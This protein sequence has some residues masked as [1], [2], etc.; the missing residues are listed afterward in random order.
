MTRLLRLFSAAGLAAA[1]LAAA[2]APAV[3]GPVCQGPAVPLPPVCGADFKGPRISCFL[4]ADVEG[5]LEQ[6]ALYLR[7]RASDLFS[8]QVL[9]ALDWPALPGRRGEP[10]PAKPI[11]APGPRVW[12]TWKETTEVFREKDGK[13]L[14][15]EPWNA[16]E[17]LPSAC[18]GAEKLLVRDEKVDDLLDSMVQPTYADGTLPGTLTDQAGRRV[19]Y[20][21]RLNRT[22]FDDIVRKGCGTA[23]S[24][25]R[26]RTS[27][28]PPARRS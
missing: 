21:I 20:E 3:S 27:A 19:R 10:D 2:Q 12:E 9:I 22:A 1:A 16:P 11:T 26:R 28:S 5:G 18:R 13:P 23:P 14:P 17:V 25:P 7:Q 6:P 15:P 8:W 24:R 4:P